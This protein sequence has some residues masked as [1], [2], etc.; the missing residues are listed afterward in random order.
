MDKF[1]KTERTKIKRMPAKGVYDKKTVYSIIDEALLCYI[2]FSEEN[3]PF[4]IPTI[5][6]RH[7]DELI[8][9]GSRA[10]RLMQHI[11]KGNDI[12]VN[13]TLLDG[14]VLAR[15]VFHHSMNYRSVVMFGQGRL[16]DDKNE[17]MEALEVLTEHL[18]R[19]RWKDARQ[20]NKAEF[21]KTTV[22]KMPI[23]ETS[24]KIRIGPPGDDA[25]DYDLPIWAGVIPIQTSFLP[26]ETDPH[27]KKEAPIP[28]YAQK[29][30]RKKLT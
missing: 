26:P 24:S 22:V 11:Q 17:K 12:C 27:Q 9:H 30:T 5:H 18:V 2:G 16:I 3:Q 6:A 29:Y 1:K 7:G 19:G 23:T 10:S 28:E 25:E 14:L 4:V 15:S 8:F 20:P 21:I 13:I